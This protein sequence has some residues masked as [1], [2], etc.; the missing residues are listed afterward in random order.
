MEWSKKADEMS[1]EKKILV[2]FK[3]WISGEKSIG[4]KKKKIGICE[5][6]DD[7]MWSIYTYLEFPKEKREKRERK[8]YIYSEKK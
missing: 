1:Q 8:K 5:W 4:E 6:W 7:F 2:Q 3:N